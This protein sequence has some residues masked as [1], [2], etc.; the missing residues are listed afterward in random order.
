MKKRTHMDNVFSPMPG[1]SEDMPA[2]LEEEEEEEEDDDEDDSG[3]DDDADAATEKD[4]KPG[5]KD[6]NTS[7]LRSAVG[8]NNAST[9]SIEDLEDTRYASKSRL[10]MSRVPLC[11]SLMRVPLFRR[12]LKQMT[13]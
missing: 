9:R 10:C 7:T 3:D 6:T 2:M 8:V 12:Q 11:V 5:G 1:L 4:S 13:H